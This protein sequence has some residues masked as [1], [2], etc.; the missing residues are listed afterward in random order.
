MVIFPNVHS[1]LLIERFALMEMIGIALFICLRD[2][3]AMQASTID[4]TTIVN[5]ESSTV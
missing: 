2:Q 4:L 5:L 3:I 1:T